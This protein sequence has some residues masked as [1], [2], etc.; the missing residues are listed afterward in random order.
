MGI[1]QGKTSNWEHKDA[2]DYYHTVEKTYGEPSFIVNKPKGVAVWYADRLA[3]KKL[4]GMP[5]CMTKI[6]L[7]DESIA[8]NCPSPH[9]DFI[10]SYIKIDPNPEQ[11]PEIMALSGSVG[12]DPLK[13][14]L[15]ARCGSIEA[16]I[17]TLKLVS[18][19]LVKKLT[20]QEI[21]KKDLYKKAIMST[22]SSNPQTGYTNIGQVKHLYRKLCDNLGEHYKTANVKHTGFWRGA[23]PDGCAKEQFY[24]R[25][26]LYHDAPYTYN[27]PYYPRTRAYP[28]MNPPVPIYKSRL[29]KNLYKM[30]DGY[31]RFHDNK[32]NKPVSR[33]E[34]F[35][36]TAVRFLP[37]TITLRDDVGSD[38]RD[39]TRTYGTKAQQI[40]YPKYTD[41]IQRGLIYA[42]PKSV[43][44]KVYKAEK[45]F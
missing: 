22:A 43:I 15:Y 4:F 21:K 11:L 25:R 8:H 3:D 7:R 45:G 39:I 30:I 28:K 20:I 34:H 17:A 33:N 23:F 9:R 2:A 16:N 35:A 1:A 31:E 26:S 13:K 5:N 27:H 12:F 32:P 19:L 42:P 29:D 40:T 38:K 44:T 41:L 10:E 6:V 18:D 37:G 24:E 36:E 14:T